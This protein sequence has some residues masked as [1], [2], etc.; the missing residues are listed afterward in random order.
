[1]MMVNDEGE[2]LANDIVIIEIRSFW[3]F[4]GIFTNI[5]NFIEQKLSSKF[6]K[7]NQIA[8]GLLLGKV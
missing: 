5:C 1:M 6:F 4:A 8:S 7:F 2:C 3:D